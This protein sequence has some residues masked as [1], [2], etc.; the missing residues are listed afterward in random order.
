MNNRST[1]SIKHRGAD[2]VIPGLAFIFTLYYLYSIVDAPWTAKV[3]TYFFATVLILLVIALLVRTVME[4]RVRVADLGMSDLIEPRE[5]IPKRAAL[6]VLTLAFAVLLPW[7]GFTLTTGVYLFLSM[8][9]L[10]GQLYKS[11]L[12]AITYSLG[13]Y[14][15]F[16][17]AFKT[18]FPEG[19]FE[20][21]IKSVFVNGT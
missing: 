16:I 19:P 4:M 1:K 17:V 10:G 14:L 11:A 15:L 7:G 3:S 12:L 13:G 5:Y 21:L 6:V 9:I 8:L 18:G 20:L 2:L